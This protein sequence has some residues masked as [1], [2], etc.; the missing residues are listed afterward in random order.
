MLFSIS[1]FVQIDTL[2]VDTIDTPHT[3]YS[4]VSISEY[5]E[6]NYEMSEAKGY[7]ILDKTARIFSM[8][9]N[10]YCLVDSVL[11]VAVT[12]NPTNQKYYDGELFDL[13]EIHF[14]DTILEDIEVE[15]IDQKTYDWF[16]KHYDKVGDKSKKWFYVDG[17]I[18]KE[19]APKDIKDKTK[20]K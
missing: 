10:K 20:V 5:Y 12:L 16:A 18:D 13:N 11:F 2:P 8:N 15:F 6:M 14:K 19:K 3:K 7:T 4:V 1:G 9:V 17:N